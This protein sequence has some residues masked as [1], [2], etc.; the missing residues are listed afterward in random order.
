VKRLSF[1]GLAIALALAG[2]AQAAT[3]GQ[4]GATSTGSFTVSLTVTA[5]DTGVRVYGLIDFPIQ[6]FDLDATG[7]MVAPPPGFQE[8][9][10][11]TNTGAGGLS[12]T[13]SQTDAQSGVTG[14]HLNADSDWNGDSSRS[15]LPMEIFIYNPGISPPLLMERDQAQSRAAANPAECENPSY[16]YGSH[17]I[18]LNIPQSSDVLDRGG[19]TGRFSLLVTP[20]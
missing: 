7:H 13:V 8:S 2:V 4:A 17:K 1:I 16:P 12:V 18:Y 14:F 11:M 9:F 6:P 5:P 15:A 20:G 10:C 3:D 19:Y